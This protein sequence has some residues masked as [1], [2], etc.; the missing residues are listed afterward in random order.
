MD[1]LISQQPKAAY[2]HY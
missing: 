1:S 2:C